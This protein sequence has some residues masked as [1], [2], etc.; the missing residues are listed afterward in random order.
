MLLKVFVCAGPSE[1][2]EL[3]TEASES[4]FYCSICHAQTNWLGIIEI[5]PKI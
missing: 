3:R 2:V 5:A 1:H 4:I